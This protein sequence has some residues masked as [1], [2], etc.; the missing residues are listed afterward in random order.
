MNGYLPKIVDHIDRNPSNNKIENLRDASRSLNCLNSKTNKNID[1]IDRDGV[2]HIGSYV[3][4]G[5]P[6]FVA[7]DTNKN[8][9]K[10]HY[11]K[12]AEVGRIEQV[13]VIQNENDPQNL[14]F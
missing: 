1:G 7:F 13:A 11:H 2:P 4:K 12:D 9:V 6:E 14:K 10:V 5:S 3:K 8:E